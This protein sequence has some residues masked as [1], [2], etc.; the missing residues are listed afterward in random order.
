MKSLKFPFEPRRRIRRKHIFGDGSKD[1]HLSYED[2]LRGTMF[3]SIDRV[4]TKVRERFQQLQN[5]AQK[6]AFLRPEVILSMG[7]LNLHQAPQ[8]INK[9]EF[10]LERVRL[11]TFVAAI[12]PGWA[13]RYNDPPFITG[14]RIGQ[15]AGRDSGVCKEQVL[16]GC[17]YSSA[18]E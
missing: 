6:Y 3:S 7:E 2:E 16:V 5:L 9:E 8:D 14:L 4:I 15:L 11:I 12:D 10:Q 18:E 1:V 13:H 17:N